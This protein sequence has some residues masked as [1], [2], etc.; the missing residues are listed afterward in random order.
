MSSQLAYALNWCG[1]VLTVRVVPNWLALDFCVY[2][3]FLRP[4]VR[5]TRTFAM[6][7]MCD[8][9]ASALELFLQWTCH[10]LSVPH[11]LNLVDYSLY[12]K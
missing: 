3:L 5:R 2:V 1:E 8:A 10:G 12:E 4:V 6:M 9:D 7:L 11:A